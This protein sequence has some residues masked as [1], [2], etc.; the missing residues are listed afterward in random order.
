[1]Q[2]DV[3]GLTRLRILAR[4]LAQGGAV[5]RGIENVVDDLKGEAEMIAGITQKFQLGGRGAATAAAC[6]KGS[7]Q[8][9]AS[10]VVVNEI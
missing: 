7:G 2:R 1:M 10:L 6:E 5:G 4:G 8:D 3:G 9:G